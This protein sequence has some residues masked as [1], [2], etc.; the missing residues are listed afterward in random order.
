MFQKINFIC[1]CQYLIFKTAFLLIVTS[2]YWSSYTELKIFFLFLLG[3]PILKAIKNATGTS[4]IFS[5]K[6][7]LDALCLCTNNR[8]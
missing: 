2:Y 8:P 1:L 7:Q 5:Y 3:V 6:Y 4:V